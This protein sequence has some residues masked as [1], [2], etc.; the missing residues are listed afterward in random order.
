MMAGANKAYDDYI[1]AEL[2][3]LEILVFIRMINIT[4]LFMILNINRL[5]IYK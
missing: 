3:K 1:I 5:W 4:Y 2:E